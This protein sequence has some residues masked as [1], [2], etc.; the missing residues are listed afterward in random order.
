MGYCHPF[1][2]FH[3]PLFD[4]SQKRPKALGLKL[5]AAPL[6][7]DLRFSPTSSGNLRPK[8][9]LIDLNSLDGVVQKVEIG[10]FDERNPAR[11][12]KQLLCFPLRSRCFYGEL[13]PGFSGLRKDFRYANHKARAPAGSRLHMYRSAVL[14]NDLIGDKK[15]QTG[16]LGPLG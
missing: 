1:S 3:Q 5:P 9:L 6:R 10:R 12:G 11:M 8:G 7:R 4:F 14:A 16:S 15:P 2:L 13:L